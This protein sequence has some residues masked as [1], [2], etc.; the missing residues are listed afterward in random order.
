MTFGLAL[1]G[2]SMWF[3]LFDLVALPFQRA[4]G[5]GP[6]AGAVSPA[7]TPEPSLSANHLPPPEPSRPERSLP[8]VPVG[9][10]RE[11]EV[12]VT[13]LRVPEGISAAEIAHILAYYGVVESAE[14]FVRLA[15]QRGVTTRLH[16]GTYHFVEGEALDQVLDRLAPPPLVH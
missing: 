10:I 3:S 16:A 2:L 15:R 13:V 8:D 14:A 11:R 9:R 4:G 6:A 7:P 5:A 1:V 12:V